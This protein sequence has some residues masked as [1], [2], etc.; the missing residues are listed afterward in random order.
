MNVLE[1]ERVREATRLLHSTKCEIIGESFKPKDL[2]PRNQLIRRLK[3]LL[4]TCKVKMDD[5][6]VDFDKL[7]SY[8]ESDKAIQKYSDIIYRNQSKRSDKPVYLRHDLFSP[9]KFT[10]DESCKVRSARIRTN[11][12]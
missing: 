10:D 12:K 8:E 2:N 3:G 1:E 4:R 6:E 5:K 11:L 7:I 9:Y